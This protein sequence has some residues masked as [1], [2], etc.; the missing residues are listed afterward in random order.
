MT[1][2]PEP[3]AP[4]QWEVFFASQLSHEAR[5]GWSGSAPFI[6]ANYGAV[7]NL[8]LHLILPMAFD[9]PEHAPTHY[10]LGDV[11]I[12]AKYRF[13]QETRCR[14]QVG[15]YPLLVVPTGAEAR[16]L[17]GGRYQAFLP[18]WV[19]KSWGDDGR[20]WTAYGG[21]GYWFNPGSHNRNWAHAGA[22]LQKRVIDD[23][24]LGAELFHKT[25]QQIGGGSATWINAGA[26]YDLSETYHLLFSAG[27]DVTGDSGFQTF[28]GVRFNFPS[29]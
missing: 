11:E 5:G 16:G 15:V 12:G 26:I 25:P 4:G 10:G 20:E 28:V 14:P 7:E 2:D 29:P 6:D 21:G 8:Q 3:I 9:S 18:V 27:H 24:T 13:V 17:G 23:L 22:L 19:Q 1:D